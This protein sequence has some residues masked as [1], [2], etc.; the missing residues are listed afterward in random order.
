MH[1]N[2]L[3]RFDIE[4]SWVIY[5]FTESTFLVDSHPRLQGTN[6]LGKTGV[7]ISLV[8]VERNGDEEEFAGDRDWG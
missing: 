2:S 4:N 1:Q 8:E 5:D 3:F 7:P 6:V